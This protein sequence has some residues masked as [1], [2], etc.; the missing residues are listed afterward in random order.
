MRTKSWRQLR[1]LLATAPSC[2]LAGCDL[3]SLGL[4]KDPGAF[5]ISIGDTYSGE[6]E[7]W[8]LRV[9]YIRIDAE[10][11]R[12][13]QGRRSKSRSDPYRVRV[14]NIS[15]EVAQACLQTRRLSSWG[16]RATK[17]IGD[18]LLAPGEATTFG[19]DLPLTRR[20][21]SKQRKPRPRRHDADQAQLLW[22]RILGDACPRTPNIV[23]ILVDDMGR[24]DIR[25]FSEDALVLPNIDRFTEEGIKL[26]S[27]YGEASCTPARAALLTGSYGQRVSM[28]TFYGPWDP[29][30]LH[31]NEVTIAEVVRPRAYVSALV[32]KWHLGSRRPLLPID[33]GFDEFFGIPYSL[34]LS[35]AQNP[36]QP[37][38]P[39]YEGNHIIERGLDDAQHTRRFTERAVEFIESN[40]DQPFFL[41]LAHP[42]PHVPLGVSDAFVGRSGQGLYG[43]VLMELDWSVGEIMNALE[44]TGIDE[45][46]L[47]LFMSDNGPWLAFG[48]HAGSALPLREGKLTG[49]EGGVRVPALARWPGRIP[50]GSSSDDVAGLVD[51]L[52]TIA[53]LVGG[54][55][56]DDRTL[57][58]KSMVGTLYGNR[59][60]SEIAPR[61]DAPRT[62]IYHVQGMLHAIRVGRFK[63]HLH[64]PYRFVGRAG[65]DGRR[66]TTSHAW[67]EQSLFDLEK[68]PGELVDVSVLYPDVLRIML[69]EA[70]RARADL[71]DR[72]MGVEGGD[73]RPEGG[74]PMTALPA[75]LLDVC[76]ARDGTRRHSTLA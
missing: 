23:V 36:Y 64:H 58:G 54:S 25:A 5:G 52:P 61:A 16:W 63:L 37:L 26:T 18:G 38:L 65:S 14:E 11:E 6:V 12:R 44:R 49:F 66:G 40:A 75:A 17:V 21:F 41:Y 42:M 10:G 48:N 4:L 39:L 72:L 57:D 2:M 70:E 34:D 15:T 35:Q 43:D 47:V 13:N 71:G 67:I 59:I 73:V 7:I 27:F 30:G 22:Q 31:P 69:D 9:S 3:D 68:D 28:P 8:P 20:A 1:A 56:P 62:M 46:T 74:V 76:S 24:S 55:L 29:G 45:N 19:A 51:L 60:P 33:Q 53:E 32:G 50:G